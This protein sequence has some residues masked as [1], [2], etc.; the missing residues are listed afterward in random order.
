MSS[1]HVRLYIEAALSFAE[2][3]NLYGTYA[4]LEQHLCHGRYEMALQLV[5]RLRLEDNVRIPGSHQSA[6]VLKRNE[7]LLLQL[8]ARIEEIIA[9]AKAEPVSRPRTA[10]MATTKQVSTTAY[11]QGK[12]SATF[13]LGAI[14][15]GDC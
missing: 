12:A 15:R 5:R 9:A 10:H 2:H 13:L 8:E 11:G 6:A 3:M 14:G 7:Y 4:E 1:R